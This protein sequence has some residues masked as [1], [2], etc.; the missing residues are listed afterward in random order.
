MVKSYGTQV[1]VTKSHSKETSNVSFTDIFNRS[2]PYLYL[3]YL[4][5]IIM[6]HVQFPCNHL[7]WEDIT[8]FQLTVNG[9]VHGPII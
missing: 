8:N 7:D 4:E 5:N 6:G 3:P 2:L 9:N 1:C